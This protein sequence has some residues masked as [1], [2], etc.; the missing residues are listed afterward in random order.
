MKRGSENENGATA[1]VKMHWR[2]GI[3]AETGEAAEVSART[4]SHLCRQSTDR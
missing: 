4:Q 3:M 1:K 2:E